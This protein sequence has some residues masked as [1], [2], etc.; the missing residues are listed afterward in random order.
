MCLRML[1]KTDGQWLLRYVPR[2]KALTDPPTDL[3]TF[4]KQRRRWTNGTLLTS[5][6]MVMNGCKVV[7]TNHS[8]TRKCTFITMI[9]YILINLC[10]QILLVGTLFA[11]FSIFIRN[12]LEPNGCDELIVNPAYMLELAYVGLLMLFGL[13]SLTKPIE[14]S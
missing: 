13:L 12:A 4:I 2:A 11:S 3:I 5:M 6:N 7:G 1:I 8:R 10:L 9:F 14:H